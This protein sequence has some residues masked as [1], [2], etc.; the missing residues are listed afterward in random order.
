MRG[1]PLCLL[2]V[3]SIGGFGFAQMIHLVVGEPG[4]LRPYREFCLSVIVASSEDP[5]AMDEAT[6]AAMAEKHAKR[7]N[8]PYKTDRSADR[9]LEKRKTD[10]GKLLTATFIAYSN[11]SISDAWCLVLQVGASFVIPGTTEPAFMTFW[12]HT[13]ISPYIPD[14]SDTE[15]WNTVVS[16]MLE[17]FNKDWKESRKYK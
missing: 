13:V 15:T 16:K 17:R 8:L 11:S 12:T 2:A 5:L 4:P 9:S 10:R 7:L 14:R 6:L 3:L 1:V